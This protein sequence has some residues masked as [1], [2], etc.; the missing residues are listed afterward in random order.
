MK[1]SNQ[2]IKVEGLS[3]LYRLG[4][5][6]EQ[7]ENL[8][9][10]ILNSATNPLKNYR[11]YRS[12]YDFSD[13][14]SGTAID[15]VNAFW[16]LKDISFEVKTGEVLGIVG[17]N[18]AG[19]S[20]LL[21]ILARITPPT[22]GKVTLN[23]RLSSLLEVGTG[24]HPELTGRENVYLNGSI[25]GMRKKEIDAKFDEIVDFSGV[26]RFLDT[27]VK[28][29]SSGMRVRLA[30]A[31]A[32]HLEPEIL[33]V[34]EVLAVGDA[35]FQRKCL[36][37]MEKSGEDGKTILF[38]SHNMQA[39]ARLCSRAIILREGQLVMDG[40]TG[41]VLDQYLK[42]ERQTCAVQRW[43]DKET[44][45][46]GD[47]LQMRA[48]RVLNSDGQIAE[49]H[50]IRK[51][52]LVELEYEVTKEGHSI[53]ASFSLW[54]DAE[55]NIGVAIDQDLSWRGKPRARG[56]YCSI[57]RIPGNLLAEGILSLNI[58]MWTMSPTRNMEFRIEKPVSFNVFDSLEGDSS[59]GEFQGDLPGLIRPMLE[60]TTKA[61]TVAS[62]S[63]VPVKLSQTP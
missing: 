51:D 21:K 38:V 10:A 18:G 23:G 52:I 4:A 20:T 29:Y 32:A 45:P 13:V 17:G 11:K 3:K 1:D 42:E 26:E 43:E 15:D 53:M 35:E 7:S 58:V 12:I 36:T 44:A 30:F 48:V 59:R 25:L 50:D 33:I 6:D 62:V 22:S 14:E 41:L 40:P 63:P 27:P 56:V 57:A 49:N 16:A 54:N 8:I 9:G 39:I 24:F 60:W 37:K 55:V 61:D 46:A 28:R 2:A 47:V 31:V 5:A 19:K 34:D